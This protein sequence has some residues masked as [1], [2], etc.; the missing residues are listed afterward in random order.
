MI[1]TFL[2]VA[3]KTPWAVCPSRAEWFGR[4]PWRS[5]ASSSCRSVR[6]SWRRSRS[7][8][9]WP[10]CRWRRSALLCGS[11]AA[12]GYRRCRPAPS[13]RR[14][15]SGCSTRATARCAP[16]TRDLCGRAAESAR[17]S[18]AAG[19]CTCCRSSGAACGSSGGPACR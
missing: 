4:A 9:R 15:S 5:G 8:R 11:S 3:I 12:C 1:L 13:G 2:Y 18:P 16:R 14:S 6:A 17:G 19:C 7:R 10:A